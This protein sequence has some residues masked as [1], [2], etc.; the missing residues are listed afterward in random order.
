MAKKKLS[1]REIVDKI[2]SV[3][4]KPI[5]K[6]KRFI[7]LISSVTLLG[8]GGITA[9]CILA[10][11]NSSVQ[12]YYQF[13]DKYFS[14]KT[15]AVAYAM[16]SAQRKNL[17]YNTNNYLFEGQVFSTQSKLNDYI[18][19]RFPISTIKTIRNPGEYVINSSGELSRDVLSASYEKPTTVYRGNDGSAYLTKDEAAST[20]YNYQKV[21]NIEGQIRYNEYEARELY[22][23]SIK[24]KLEDSLT[25]K[26]T[27]YLQG[28]ICQTEQEIKNWLRSS[29]KNG[30]EYRGQYFSDYNFSEFL[31]VMN[32]IDEYTVNKHVKEVINPDKN[33]YWISQD[34]GND[35][36]NSY[37]IGPKYVETTQ[38]LPGSLKFKE[39]SSFTP[40]IF[41][42]PLAFGAVDSINNLLFREKVQKFDWNSWTTIIDY[43]NFLHNNISNE[44]YQKLINTI[45]DLRLPQNIF[46]DSVT[47]LG[48]IKDDSFTDFHKLLVGMK[49]MLT[50]TKVYASSVTNGATKLGNA[51]KGIIVDILN[52][53]KET[54]GVLM[55]SD[56]GANELLDSGI[57]FDDIYNM[58]L[59]Q[60]A[61]FEEGGN[62]R[63]IWDIAQKIQSSVDNIMSVVDGANKIADGYQNLY[64]K[65]NTSD[66]QIQTGRKQ[67]SHNLKS[68]IG[69]AM[70]KILSKLK[71]VGKALPIANI[72]SGIWELSKTF[73]F[74]SLKTLE[75]KI[76]HNNSIYYVTPTFKLPILD[77]EFTSSQL[78]TSVTPLATSAL[79][80]MLPS[81]TNAK[82]Q[83][84]YEF[85][86]HYYLSKAAAKADLI[87]Q[88][89]LHPERYVSNRKLMISIMAKDVPYWLPETISNANI[90]GTTADDSNC[91][92][93]VD[94]DSA[95][96]A[97]KDKF[98]N[99]IFTEHFKPKE[100]SFY[101]DGFG[102]YF[103]SK[104]EAL[105]SLAEN[106]A[107]GNFAVT[108]RYQTRTG[109]VFFANSETE[110]V[111][112]INNNE[113]I[114]NKQVIN[115]DLIT[116]SHYNNLSDYLG[117]K[118]DIY[119]LDYYGDQK[120][121]M[122]EQQAWNYLWNHIN[123]Q[124]LNF[125]ATMQEFKFGTNAFF[126]K[127]DFITWIN[128]KIVA[129]QGKKDD[130]K[131]VN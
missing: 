111:N 16:S 103:L 93:Q 94:Y 105:A 57:S 7:S 60:G 107:L 109:K 112:F 76:D 25:G 124:T 50:Y 23:N 38:K 8:A 127:N 118:F 64:K 48:N 52:N 101:L 22:E 72:F 122:S 125:D 88:I 40:S 42:A 69:S 116:T 12:T 81:G 21:Y 95:V 26:T 84:L 65:S 36:L 73:S 41:F 15:A 34:K 59:N 19:E 74:I 79:N 121:F 92:N 90:C 113:M 14:T 44:N 27:C 67:L 20:F 117:M 47:N 98:I 55:H 104:D 58:F 129:V 108:Y 78:K 82:D 131:V 35:Y 102:N 61:F 66:K 39:V 89:Y 126:N 51:F 130:R 10:S 56:K 45:K 29:V 13:D 37:F 115:S 9:G 33:S 32:S 62:N 3:G 80:Y 110:M 114:D 1:V 71:L 18:Q 53:N 6:S 63:K 77:I 83:K 70:G 106:V 87:R 4:Q 5:W 31:T 68:A 49:R 11:Q 17:S 128:A 24:K 99:Q 28:A 30:F 96:S 123:Y 85:N 119:T 75:A 97:E 120:Y 54:M 91:I 46:Q 43:L 100:Q 2:F 86:D